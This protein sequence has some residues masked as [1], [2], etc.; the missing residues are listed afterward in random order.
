VVI[1]AGRSSVRWCFLA[2]LFTLAACSAALPIPTT[3]P[4]SA[5][6]FVSPRAVRAQAAVGVV[7]STGK[8]A[9]LVYATGNEKNKAPFCKI[10]AAGTYPGALAVDPN[11]DLWVPGGMNSGLD[12]VVVQYKPSCG[13]AI[14]TLQDP[15]AQVSDIAVAQNGTVYVANATTGYGSLGDVLVYPKGRATPSRYLG[16]HEYF[17]PYG[18]AVDSL[19]NVY[20]AYDAG[21][22]STT[23]VLVFVNA[24]GPGRRLKNFRTNEIGSFLFDRNNDLIVSNGSELDIYAPPYNGEPKAYALKGQSHQCTLNAAQSTLSCTDSQNESVDVY[25]Y[26]ALTY[27]YSF[28]NGIDGQVSGIAESPL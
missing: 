23:G 1:F 12:S 28:N 25:N 5:L 7:N 6:R 2:L 21:T 17:Y 24:K 18:I 15:Y 9:I 10:G 11:G 14:L 4:A 13:P 20:V 22:G 19:N 3:S 26:P 8:S 27:R 16:S